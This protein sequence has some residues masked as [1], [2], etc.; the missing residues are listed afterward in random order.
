MLR[1]AF[2]AM[3][4]LAGALGCSGSS[5]IVVEP[6]PPPPP[7]FLLEI[8]GC[9]GHYVGDQPNLIAAIRAIES[10]NP[11]YWNV[12]GPGYLASD[13]EGKQPISTDNGD[14]RVVWY[15]PPASIP[16]GGDA[17][18]RIYYRTLDLYNGG[19]KKSPECIQAIKTLKVPMTFESA[20]GNNDQTLSQGGR[21]DIG[22][23]VF[24]VPFSW[25]SWSSVTWRIQ[26]VTPTQ[27]LPGTLTINPI[28]NDY[29]GSYA[30]Y[31][32]PISVSHDFDVTIT[33]TTHDPW[34]NLDPVLTWI[35]HVKKS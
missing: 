20:Y 10:L 34:F 14:W 4:C 26:G 11:V 7:E 35:V 12:D 27:T 2:F 9:G 25:D 22:A 28:Q 6:P 15:I 23:R 5:N 18:T 24:P 8:S 1:S 17:T 13:K 16:G 21:T 30:I 33:A 32:A 29:R 3:A 31:T 19:L